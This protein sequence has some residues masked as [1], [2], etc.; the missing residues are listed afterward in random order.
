MGDDQGFGEGFQSG[1]QLDDAAAFTRLMFELYDWRCAIAARRF[2]PGDD[3]LDPA[4]EVFLFEPLGVGGLLSFHNAIVVEHAAARLLYRGLVVI[5]D[6][7]C[8]VVVQTGEVGPRFTCL[9]T[10]RSG[11]PAPHSSF[12]GKSTPSKTC[13]KRP[14]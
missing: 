9:L 3:L 8:P 14:E 5:N 11:Q 1:F 7:Y 4:L 2:P 13:A 12:I 10:R 6:D